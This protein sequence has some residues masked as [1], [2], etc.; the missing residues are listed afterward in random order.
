[1]VSDNVQDIP[2]DGPPEEGGI[3]WIDPTMQQEISW[4]DGDI[5]VSVPPKSGTTWTMNIVHQLRSGGD[6]DFADVYA[7]VPWLEFVPGPTADRAELVAEFE[8]L[9][10]ERRRAFKSHSAPPDLPYVEPGTGPD[11]RYLV[12]VR[13]PDEAVAS[14]WPFLAAHSDAWFELW[15][16]PKDEVLGPDL[17]TFFEHMGPM[18]VGTIFGAV[19]AWWPLRDRPNVHLVHFNDLKR[20][21]E[22]SVRRIAEFLG[23]DPTPEQWDAVLEYTSFTWMK[24]HEDKFELRT[25]GEVPPLDP[26]AMIRKGKIGASAEDGVTPEMSAAIRAMGSE[27]VTDPVALAWCYAGGALTG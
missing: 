18:L 26:G 10:R 11:V 16:V 6:A 17:A 2:V 21:P 25:I 15:Q 3:P 1:V 20:E 13:N 22:A 5:V 23:F 8:R 7:E 9:T 14:M 4:R 12:T 24:A 19:A 27:I